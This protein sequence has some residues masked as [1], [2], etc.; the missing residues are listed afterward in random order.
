MEHSIVQQILDNFD[1]A[2]MLAINILTYIHY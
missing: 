1:A 2:Y